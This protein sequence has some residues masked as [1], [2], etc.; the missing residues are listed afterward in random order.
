[1]QWVLPHTEYLTIKRMK[2]EKTNIDKY[3]TWEAL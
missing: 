3:L 1:M 2:K